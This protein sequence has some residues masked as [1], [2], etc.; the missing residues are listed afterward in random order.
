MDNRAGCRLPVAC[1][2]KRAA[3]EMIMHFTVPTSVQ[4]EH[5]ELHAELGSAM[6]AG[7]RTGEAARSVAKLMHP[8]F[9]KEEAYALPPLG[10]LADVARGLAA[11]EMLEVLTMTDKLKGDLPDMLEEHKAIVAALKELISA[12]TEEGHSETAS[13]ARRLMHHAI[14]EEQVMYPAAL[15]VGE[16]LRLRRQSAG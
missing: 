9:V 3:K 2:G 5:E 7:G 14:I 6:K 15:L 11:P 13:F 1:L 4:E 16:Y 8:H 12:A 10:L